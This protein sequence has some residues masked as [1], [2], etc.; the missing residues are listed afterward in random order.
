[1]SVPIIDLFAG[2]GGLGEGFSQVGWKEGKPFFSIG[3]SVE[4]EATAHKTLRL[5]SFLRQFHYDQIPVE[6][7]AYLREGRNPE[8]LYQLP[9]YQEQAQDSDLEAWNDELRTDKKFNAQ[10]DKRIKTALKGRNDWVLIGGPPCQAYSLVGRSRNMGIKDYVA[11]KDQ[12][13]FLY[14][15]YLRII[16]VHNPAVFVME[17]VKG[18]L[19]AK[20]HGERIFPQIK[21][22]LAVPGGKSG[23]RYRIFSLIS[24]PENYDENGNP[25]FDDSDFVIRTEQYGVP[26]ARHRVILLGVREDLWDKAVPGILRITES[27]SVKKVLNLPELRSGI[28]R[29][30]YNAKDWRDAVQSFPESAF[31]SINKIAGSAIEKKVRDVLK[32]ISA[33]RNR[34]GEFVF[35]TTKS[36]KNEK[37]DAWLLDSRTEGAFNHTSR[38]HIVGDL[39][40]YLYAACFA[41]QKGVS[42]KMAEFPD[43]LKP[44]HK[45]RDTG[46]FADRFR[47]QVIDQPAKTITSHISKDGH[48][49]IH[50]DPEQCRSLTVREAARIQ[51]FPDNYFFCGNRTSQYVQVGNAVPPL[52][53]NQIAIV[54]KDLLKEAFVDI[55]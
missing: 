34:G 10:L 23:P 50:P 11:E 49:Y 12:R 25:V 19:S 1:M 15:E 16:S 13:H 18:I 45:N 27:V 55:D 2:P 21:K 53:A 44:N 42:P 17:N 22:D 8:E 38:S 28:S 4:K 43:V 47:V 52:L 26:Q 14:K 29:G 37:L 39:H 46:H 30:N 6:Y 33:A 48:Y 9:Q 31:P 20:L 3:L 40:R 7:F 41:S 36:L 35:Q 5:R 54:V 32:S 24:K 51:T